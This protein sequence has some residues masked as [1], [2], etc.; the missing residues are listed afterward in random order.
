MLP[1]SSYQAP[2]T[3]R[4]LRPFRLVQPNDELNRIPSIDALVEL[5]NASPTNA[6]NT[7]TKEDLQMLIANHDKI[8]NPR[9]NENAK[10]IGCQKADFDNL[11]KLGK[12]AHGTVYKVRSK[13]NNQLYVMK[14]IDFATK[15]MQIGY[16]REALREV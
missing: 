1:Y 14:E 10:R 15:G 12:G 4:G 2:P 9:G 6:N 11:E 8:V 3:K 16:K 5:G 13:K 7:F